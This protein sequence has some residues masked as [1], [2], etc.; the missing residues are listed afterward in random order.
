MVISKRLQCQSKSDLCCLD[1]CIQMHL[2]AQRTRSGHVSAAATW[3][4]LLLL[5][6]CSA[7]LSGDEDYI[8]QGVDILYRL[9]LTA[10]SSTDNPHEKTSSFSTTYT[11]APSHSN[12]PVSGYGVL[13]DSNFHY[14]APA[15][16]LFPPEIGEEF[17]VVVSLSSWRANNA[18]L[19]SVKD[20]RDRLR[21]G[22]QLLP[23]RVV[24]YTAEKTSIYFTYNWQ[25]GRQHPFAVGVRARSVSF[26][27]E[28]GAVQQ[29]EHT[30]GRSQTLGDSGGLF[31]LGRMNSKAASF[32]GRVCQ[33]DI[34][35][36]A[37]AAAHYC[38]YL[39]K[40]C[41]L[42][43]TYRLPLPHPD[44][45][46]E[47]NDP[48]SDPSTKSL[49]GISATHHTPLKIT[50]AV[51]L[52]PGSLVLQN[53]APSPSVQP[54]LGNQSHISTSDPHAHSTTSLLQAESP[55]L[56][57]LSARAALDLTHSTTIT[58]SRNVLAKGSSSQGDSDLSENSTEEESS[59]GSLLTTD[60][61]PELISPVRQSRVKEG[62]R[63]NN[64]ITSS[65]TTTTTT[66]QLLEIHL[67]ANGT[68]L[69]RE[70]QVDTSE[71]HDMDGSYDDVDMGGYD[72]GYEET[73]FFYDYEDGFRGPKGEP[74]PPG[75]PGPPGLPGPRGKR[76]SRGPTGPH[77]NPGLPG[78]PGPKGA[79]GDP[80]LS[81]GQAPP[82][83]KGDRGP[84]G[85]PGPD[86]FPGPLVI[87]DHPD[88]QESKAYQGLLGKLGLQVT[89][90]GRA[91][92]GQK[93][94]Q[95]L[96]VY[97][98][99]LGLLVLL[100]H[101]GWRG[102]KAFLVLLEILAPKEDTLKANVF[103]PQGVVGDAGERGP[104]GPD[105]NE[106]PVGGA[107]IGGFPGLR[108]EPGPEGLRG[109][110]GLVGPQG[111]AG[112]A[113]LPGLKVGQR[114]EPGEMGYQGDKGAAGLPGP[115][116]PR[117]KP[118][119][120]GKIGEMGVQ[121][122]PGPPGPEG[123]PGD[124]G[125]PGSNGPPG[126]KGMQGARGPQGPQGPKG[127][128]GEEG[129]LG[130]P[131]SAGPTGR[132]GRKGYIGEPGPEGLKGEKGDMGN[133]GKIGPQGPVGLIGI[134]G[135]IGVPG[136]KGDRGPAGPTGP[137][138][139]KGPRGYPGLAGNP[140]DI[141]MQ[142]APGPQGQR[143]APGIAGAK[144]RRKILAMKTS[145]IKPSVVCFAS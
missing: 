27:A 107:G 52:S 140:G 76:G 92:L 122:P 60:A 34:Y 89:L 103:V 36:S 117:G 17:S 38:N 39:K 127:I 128:Q 145:L 80:G 83:E 8:A 126:P 49:V 101:Q 87:Q 123:F 67:R 129:P 55:T 125:I 29:Q 72:Y 5:S 137:V 7:V 44:L 139:E 35:P 54:H 43:D 130:P 28:C 31:T 105:G 11:T 106:G 1:K 68:T 112:R 53:S 74:G 93:V 98:V 102:R 97:V 84:P 110:P 62:L 79:K 100:G 96:K 104:P 81:P 18:F 121:G 22:I 15:G 69:Y 114:G 143:G 116:G 144:G 51:R 41:R 91:Q 25:D 120:P 14:E 78:P 133:V 56:P 13:L 94:T 4:F 57:A 32:N 59:S 136:E 134:A 132:P 10:Q 63:N 95:G 82:G 142:G 70:N 115:L 47:A 46:I 108:G 118:G 135:V 37:Q 12:V 40:Q 9:G 71:H 138:G 6:V 61:T 111:P 64:S 48:P 21:F 33:L 88:C 50:P 124:I 73:D 16:S 77:G 99:S 65:T 86:G 90:A 19:F 58:T 3:N 23:R 119:P 131:G 2:G 141:G 45:D 75:P 24:V 66:H 109:L 42:A 20:G 113:G 26:Y 85:L 30:L